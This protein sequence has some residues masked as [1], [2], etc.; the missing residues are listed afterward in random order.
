MEEMFAPVLNMTLRY[1]NPNSFNDPYDCY[2]AAKL[3]GEIQPIRSAGVYVC[4]LTTSFD[5]MLMWSHYASNHGGFVVEY[6][7]KELKKIDKYQMESF[8]KVSYS[9]DIL[10]R[11]LL[12]SNNDNS[13]KEIV[14]AIYHKA[15][16]WSYENEIRSVIYEIESEMPID[17]QLESNCISGIF[18]G[19]HFIKRRNGK[20]PHFLQNWKE[21][22]KLYYMQ[23][24]SNMYKLEKKQDIADQLFE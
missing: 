1:R 3:D 17:I 6:D 24:S 8:S 18:L 12:S 14:E 23:L 13:N 10:L 16:C 21:K 20:I 11:N 5:D 9:D 7:A 4:S 15:R 22:K 19:S 2:I